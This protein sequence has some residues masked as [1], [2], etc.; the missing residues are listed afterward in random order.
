MKGLIRLADVLDTVSETTGR[1]VSWL[2]VAMVL[3]QFA[4][5]VMR[6]VFGL[7]SIAMQ[8]SVIYMHGI[9]F[10]VAAGYTLL[11]DAHVRVDVFYREA[12]ERARAW[13]NLIGVFGFLVPVCG[14]IWYVSWDYVA[15]SWA[16]LE[17]SRETSGIQG[18]YLLKSVI[19]VFVALVVLQGLSLA[20]RAAVV[21]MGGAPTAAPHRDGNVG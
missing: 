2:A 10:M 14:L 16:V 8:E 18:V 20:A 11:H 17:G 1:I 4:L 21:L 7:A 3:V 9:L 15:R 12:G 19:L 13:I 5:V 6:Y